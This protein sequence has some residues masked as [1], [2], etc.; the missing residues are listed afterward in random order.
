MHAK[1]PEAPVVI[2]HSLADAEIALEV[3]GAAGCNLILASAEGAGAAAG[4]LW[5]RELVTA[6][7]ARQG[8]ARLAAG[9]DCGP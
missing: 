6:A 7:E 5:F 9:I 1:Q 8:T 2:V 4:P 3:A